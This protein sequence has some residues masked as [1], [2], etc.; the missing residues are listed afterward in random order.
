MVKS[1]VTGSRMAVMLDVAGVESGQE[2]FDGSLRIHGVLS[3][4]VRIVR[5]C[6]GY[7]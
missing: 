2:S 4:W 1:S 7:G 6:E 3:I 5:E